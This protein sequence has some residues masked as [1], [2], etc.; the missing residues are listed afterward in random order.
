MNIQYPRLKFSYSNIVNLNWSTLYYVEMCTN[1]QRINV[2]IMAHL[3][4][5]IFYDN[6]DT[7]V[8]LVTLNTAWEENKAPGMHSMAMR[9]PCHIL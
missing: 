3:T 6:Y 1:D 2:T 8:V 4:L 7:K 5:F 9:D